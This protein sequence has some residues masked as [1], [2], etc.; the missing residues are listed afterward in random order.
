MPDNVYAWAPTC[1]ALT[2]VTAPVEFIL[3]GMDPIVPRKVTITI[4]AGHSGL[5][6]IGVAF[7]HNVVI[8]ANTGAFISGDDDLFRFDLSSYPNGVTWSVFMVN[9][10]LQAH[11]WQVIFEGDNLPVTSA[12]QI[13]APPSEA[14]VMAAAM[15]QLGGP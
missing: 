15:S 4:P 3:S 11:V 2:P 6:G 13:P 14:D 10:D 1:P 8:P 9:L 7:G 5:T 12:A